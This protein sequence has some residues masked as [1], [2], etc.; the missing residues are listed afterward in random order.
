MPRP[1]PRYLALLLA[2]VFLAA[3][4]T[5]AFAA[6]PIAKLD[7]RAVLS[8]SSAGVYLVFQLEEMRLFQVMD[9]LTELF[10]SGMLPTSKGPGGEGV[11][12][13]LRDS[14][15]RLS[16]QERRD[17]YGRVLCASDEIHVMGAL[18]ALDP[19]GERLAWLRFDVLMGGY[20]KAHPALGK[21]ERWQL[22]NSFEGFDSGKLDNPLATLEDADL[23]MLL[24]VLQSVHAD[25]EEE[26]EEA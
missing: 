1:K 10:L 23:F 13:Y 7:D 5:R 25:V 14:E 26:D 21:R 11:Y 20:M 16:E 9:A 22:L 15:D 2:S 12:D 3:H 4:G 18:L 19:Q 24:L 6:E 17:L 8:S